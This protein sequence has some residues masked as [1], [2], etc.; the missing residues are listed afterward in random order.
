[1]P[2][3][4]ILM[5]PKVVQHVPEGMGHGVSNG[6]PISKG[7]MYLVGRWLLQKTEFSSNGTHATGWIYVLSRLSAKTNL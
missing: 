7:M 4:L 3:G 1:M 2:H 5:C 6:V